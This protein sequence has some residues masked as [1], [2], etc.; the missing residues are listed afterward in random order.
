MAETADK[1]CTSS[2]TE[3]GPTSRTLSI[4]I[5][6]DV[7]TDR[8]E[9][10]F[11]TLRTEAALPGFRKGHAP[12]GLLEKRFGEHVRDE[13]KGQLL[14]SAYAEAIDEHGLKVVGNPIADQTESIE[15]VEG[16]PLSFS[17]EVEIVPTFEIPELSGIAVKRPVVEVTDEQIAGE[18][19]RLCLGEGDLEDRD[20]AEPGD[21]ITG[22]GVM[23]AGDTVI[24]D[25]PGA[26]VQLPKSKDEGM[27]LGVVVGDLAKQLGSP[28]AGDSLT[29]TTTGPENHENEAARNAELSIGFEVE[30]VARII[31][32]EADDL[33]KRNGLDDAAALE[34]VIRS[35]LEQRVESERATLVRQ[36]IAA[37]LLKTI[38]F[39][40]PK[41]LSAQQAGNVFE[42][43]R[44]ELMQRGVDQQTIEENIA[45][46]RSA[47]AAEAL[48]ELKLL[49]I[50]SK[51]SEEK[52]VSVSEAEI[53]SAIV[54]MAR[55]RGERPEALQQQLV[56]NRQINGLYQQVMEQKAL[57]TIAQDAAIEDV[58]ADEWN[59]YAKSLSEPESE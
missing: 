11:G 55:Q 13:T 49:F 28:K 38:E 27:I 42:R 57:D 15:L 20:V 58:S 5:A 40:L 21:Y 1:I 54:S 32:A 43:R 18:V 2:V 36:Q 41:R 23:K 34:G 8:L 47:S 16:S 33:A 53:N 46:L 44:L 22:H 50:L 14:S 7:I 45:R 24:H 4:E 56:Q 35:Q 30:T 10:A 48:R 51:V 3:N 37:H 9:T 17:V 12:R 59:A 19:E 31:P 39:E 25:I 29:V 52:G 6:P 26:V